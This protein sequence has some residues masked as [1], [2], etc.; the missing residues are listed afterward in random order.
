MALTNADIDKIAKR[1]WD[2]NVKGVKA[3]DRLAGI[4]SAANKVK[5]LLVDHDEWKWL[6]NR[7]YRLAD[8]FFNRKDA[9]GSGMVDGKG[10]EVKRSMYDRIVWIDKRVR[11]LNPQAVGEPAK[12]PVAVALSDEQMEQIADKVA[13]RIGGK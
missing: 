6:T 7:V 8:L 2:I 13:Q 12:L 11:E 4:D 9:A 3:Q 5:N 10:N 1:V